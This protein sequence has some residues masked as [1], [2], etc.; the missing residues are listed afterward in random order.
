[1][2]KLMGILVCY[3]CLR[4]EIIWEFYCVENMDKFDLWIIWLII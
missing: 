1:M 2:L 3:K 4:K